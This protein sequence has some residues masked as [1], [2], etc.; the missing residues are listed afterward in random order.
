[1]LGNKFTKKKG[2]T[3][4]DRE[5]TTLTE[6]VN[7]SY[8]EGTKFVGI[9]F[10]A[11]WCAP[12][13]LMMRPLKNFYTDANLEKRQFEIVFVS[14]DKDVKGRLGTATYHISQTQ[15]HLHTH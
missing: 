1:M 15:Q 9:F 3:E 14:S 4:R 5:E 11:G 6:E 8:F 12:C 10:S 13:E 2:E 7:A